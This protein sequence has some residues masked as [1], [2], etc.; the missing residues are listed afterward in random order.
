M[1]LRAISIFGAMVFLFLAQAPPPANCGA[2]EAAR[3]SIPLYKMDEVVVTADRVENQAFRTTSSVSVMRSDEMR[4]LPLTAFSDVLQALPGFLVADRDGLGHDP[5]VTTRGFYGGGEAE[6]LLVLLDGKPINDLESGL[7]NWNLIPMQ[8]IETV[9][10]VRGASSALYG[11]AALGGVINIR[12]SSADTARS[13]LS[14]DGGSFGILNAGLK[15]QGTAGNKRYQLFASN[16]RS[17]GFRAHSTWQGTAFGGGM[18]LL[19]RDRSKLRISSMNQVVRADV[20]GPL[21]ADEL[22]RDRNASSP[23]YKADGKHE[24]RYQAQIAY[25]ARTSPR[26]EFTADLMYSHRDA[27]LIRTFANPAPI[28]DFATFAIVGYYDTS[29]YGDTKERRLHNN[30]AG[31]RLKY[32]SVDDAGRLQYRYV[33]GFDGDYGHIDNDYHRYFS[34]FAE[35]YLK[36]A[37]KP[38]GSIARGEGSRTK[39]ALYASNELRLDPWTLTLGIRYD[40][41]ND[42]YT[43]TLPDTNIAATNT[44]WSPKVGINVRLADGDG[45]SS[46]IYANANRSF[47]APTLDQLTDQR[48]IDFAGFMRVPVGPDSYLYSPYYSQA[49]P[50]SNALLRP[51]TAVSYEVGTYQRMQLAHDL[52]CEASVA[53]YQIDMNDE[54]DFDFAT[55]SYQNVQKSRHRGVESSLR[56][57]WMHRLTAFANYTWT[58]VTFRSGP[59]AGNYLQGIPRNVAACGVTYER[60]TGFKASLM[61]N[62]A[63]D[64]QLDDENDVTLPRMSTAGVRISQKLRPA[65][66]FIDIGN[67]LDKKYSSNGYMLNQSAFLYPAG[68]RVIHGGIAI[69]F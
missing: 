27:D 22:Y 24:E 53:A 2:I 14:F 43:G 57:Y 46:S 28:V 3:D 51:Q 45:Y 67:V 65:L 64:I 52:S 40:A 47:K 41:I 55:F 4:S 17:D 34:G 38:G 12:T 50:F 39:Y 33:V 29:L 60:G 63:S 7:V 11:D 32:A 42:T 23:Y 9:E 19:S 8:E 68:G 61:W 66:I 13:S 26:A 25:S 10:V 49:A 15:T 59:F 21:T 36:G 6:Y 48:V 62:F 69:D 1:R 56:L 16:E 31:A 20:P 5:I 37:P 30:E 44:A 35:D 58:S 54:I 18:T